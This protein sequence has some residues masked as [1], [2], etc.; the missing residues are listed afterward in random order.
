VNFMGFAQWQQEP[1]QACHATILS[2]YK[3]GIE[4]GDSLYSLYSALLF[5]TCSLMVDHIEDRFVGMGVG[6]GCGSV[7]RAKGDFISRVET[8]QKGGYIP[9]HI[10]KDASRTRLLL[11]SPVLLAMEGKNNAWLDA[12]RVCVPNSP[13]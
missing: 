10:K 11:F 2:A 5:V 4:V 12:C 8:G 6:A 3:A 7:K 13:N 1:V 9:L